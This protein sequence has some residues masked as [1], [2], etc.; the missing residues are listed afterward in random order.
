MW[1]PS[2]S[3]CGWARSVSSITSAPSGLAGRRA[4]NCPATGTYSRS[5]YI[6]S[7][8]G[9]APVNNPAVTVAV[10]LDSPAGPHE[11]GQVAAPAFARITQQVLAYLNVAHDVP[12]TDKRRLQLRASA[13]TG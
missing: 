8:A 1:A 13:A 9:F 12:L 6:A 5:Q 10:I 11:G 4:S 7:F 3:P 2:R